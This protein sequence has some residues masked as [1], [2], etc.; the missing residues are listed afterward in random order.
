MAV[1]IDVITQLLETI[2]RFFA[3]AAD[4]VSS[5]S[6]TTDPVLAPRTRQRLENIRSRC[7][8]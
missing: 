5:W 4:E 7:T 1:A 6:D 8:G 2:D 3:D